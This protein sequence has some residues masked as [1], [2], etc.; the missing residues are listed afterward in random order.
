MQLKERFQFQLWLKYLWVELCRKS[1]DTYTSLTACQDIVYCFSFN[2]STPVNI[3]TRYTLKVLVTIFLSVLLHFASK[4]IVKI[5][6]QNYTAIVQQ[7]LNCYLEQKA[8][9]YTQNVLQSNIM[10]KMATKLCYLE[11]GRGARRSQ[12]G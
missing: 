1:P 2:N 7:R 10:L 6:N 5:S 12:M 11:T 4:S 9:S 8:C 3:Q